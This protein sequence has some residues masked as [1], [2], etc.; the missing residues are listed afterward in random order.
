MISN[1]NIHPEVKIK[2]KDAGCFAGWDSIVIQLNNEIFKNTNPKK[3]I[4]I[5]YYQGLNE[6]EIFNSLIRKLDAD[7]VFDA[8]EALLPEDEIRKITFPDVTDDR[9]FGFITR[10]SIGDF[11]NSEKTEALR[12]KIQAI[13]KGTILI[14]GS[15]A[16]KVYPDPD[17]L[18]YADMARWEIQKRMR[19]NEVSNLG[20]TN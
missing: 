11:Q 15:G 18:V 5:E 13:E 14:Y 8:S 2:G 16:A 20:V 3:V 1:Y 9:I 6:S 10:L 17:L 7:A 19:R 4:A 12:A